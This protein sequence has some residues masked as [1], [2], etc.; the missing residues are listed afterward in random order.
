MR[1]RRKQSKQLNSN[2]KV[3]FSCRH[4]TSHIKNLDVSGVMRSDARWEIT[5]RAER[6]RNI[7]SLSTEGKCEGP[8]SNRRTAFCA[9]V[10]CMRR[11][12][13]FK[14]INNCCCRDGFVKRVTFFMGNFP[15]A[16]RLNALKS[17]GCIADATDWNMRIEDCRHHSLRESSDCTR[18]R[19]PEWGSG[20]RMCKG[21][22]RV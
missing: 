5:R 14:K 8:V 9:A 19:R 11:A 16:I 22:F 21:L 6:H 4:S 12:Y 2:T 13:R 3:L 10:V 17:D 20:G 7:P 15:E 18:D 1:F